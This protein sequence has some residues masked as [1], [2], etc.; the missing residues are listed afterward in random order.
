MSLPKGAY[1]ALEDALGSDHVCDDPA[2]TSAY[3]YMWLLY[4]TH[5]Q[6][7]RYRLVLGR[8]RRTEPQGAFAGRLRTLRR[9]L[10]YISEPVPCSRQNEF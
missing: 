6:S 7:G 5:A 9:L 10:W 8:L 2:V 4:S 1:E 3:S